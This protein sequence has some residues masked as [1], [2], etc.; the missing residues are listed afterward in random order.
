VQAA[1]EWTAPSQATAAAAAAAAAAA[2]HQE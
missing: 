1:A 2:K